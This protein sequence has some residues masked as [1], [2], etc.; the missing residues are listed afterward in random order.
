MNKKIIEYT[1]VV[2]PTWDISKAVNDMLASGWE[3]HGQSMLSNMGNIIQPL[4][5]YEQ[6][7]RDSFRDIF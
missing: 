3:I 2:E 6:L 5:K 1:V 7:S 4:V